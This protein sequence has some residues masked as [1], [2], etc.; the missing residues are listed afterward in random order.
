MSTLTLHDVC[1]A[2]RDGGYEYGALVKSPVLDVH[3]YT[4]A[5]PTTLGRTFNKPSGNVLW[6]SKITEDYVDEP[7]KVAFTLDWALDWARWVIE[8]EFNVKDYALRNIIFVK[9]DQSKLTNESHDNFRSDGGEWRLAHAIDWPKI[10]KDYKGITVSPSNAYE[11]YKSKGLIVTE[12][13]FSTWDC[14]TL[15]LWDTSCVTETMVF[16]TAGA[17]WTYKKA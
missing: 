6:C 15:A 17:E 7:S 8:E 16:H 9:V 3:E 2:A 12:N 1:I 11:R 10:A 5:D 14:E 4:P 13:L